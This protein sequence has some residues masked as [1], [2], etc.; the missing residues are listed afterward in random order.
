[1]R[2]TKAIRRFLRAQRGSVSSAALQWYARQL[3]PLAHLRRKKLKALAWSD[4]L[5]QW[6]KL[7]KKQSGGL[8][9]HS[10]RP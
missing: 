4:V 9:I 2:V 8:R 3:A 1:M 5:D 6:L 7:T 10:G